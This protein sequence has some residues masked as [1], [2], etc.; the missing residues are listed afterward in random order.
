MPK[1]RL[2][3]FRDYLD[4]RLDVLRDVEKILC[5]RQSKY[6][7]FYAEVC[8]VREEELQQL[9]S[10]I[11]A[12]RDALP[13]EFNERLDRASREAQGTYDSK[14][15]ELEARQVELQQ[16]AEE[17]RL[18]S[19]NAE[20]AVHDKNQKLDGQEEYLKGRCEKLLA[21]IEE[22]NARIREMGGGFGFFKNFLSMRRLQRQRTELEATQ[23]EIAE[24]IE[25]LRERWTHEEESHWSKEREL[26]E[27]W[28]ETSTEAAALGTKLEHIRSSGPRIVQR[29]AIEKVLY[30]YRP[31]KREIGADDPPCPRCGQP[32][33]P[34]TH[35]CFICAQRLVTDRP[36]FLGSVHEIAELNSHFDAFSEGMQACQEIIG[37][38]RGLQT[39]LQNFKESVAD[40]IRTE[41]KYPV[42]QLMISVPTK[43]V[44]YGQSF[45][46][47]G[48]VVKPARALHPKLFA[49][50]V[51]QEITDVFSEG[52]IKDFFEAMG[53]ELSREAEA[54]W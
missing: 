46:M 41:Q 33:A 6:E 52:H 12:D 19:L 1:G 3:D 17:I 10:H 50:Q 16:E 31:A 32:N 54:Q 35:F 49:A 21:D 7:S 23:K 26:R 15:T 42:S 22:H 47:L 11:L 45:E 25:F 38:V 5:A 18:Q 13:K 27:K 28:L 51:R 34:E 37:L 29:S 20:R 30:A 43:A 24:R 2:R 4:N 8:K 9:T 53:N 44:K 39:G 40:M 48:E 36:D 14:L